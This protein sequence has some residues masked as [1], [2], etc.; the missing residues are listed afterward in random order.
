MIPVLPLVLMVQT[1][2]LNE[3]IDAIGEVESHNNPHVRDGDVK[4]GRPSIGQYQ[5]SWRYWFDS[6]TPGKWSDCRKPEYARRVI[7]NYWERWERDAFNRVNPE[8]LIRSHNGGC[9]WRK[10]PWRTKDYLKR[11]QREL[12]RKSK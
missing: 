8:P 4:T 9:G 3:I 10:E 7:R 2:T 12:R 6:R 5:V 11:V 1:Y